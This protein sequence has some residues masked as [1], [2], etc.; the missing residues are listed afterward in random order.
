MAEVVI[1]DEQPIR[2]D[3]FLATKY[4]Y[5]RNFFHHIFQRWGILVNQKAVKKSYLLKIGDQITIDDLKRFF[6]PA[7]MADAP[8][9]ELKIIDEKTDYLVLYK[10]KG[11]LSHPSSIWSFHQP[12]VTGFLYHHYK[13]LPSLGS[14][15]RAGLIHRLDKDTDGLMLIIKSERWLA[16]FKE[17]FQQKS[18]A[19]TLE[20]KEL[21]PLKKFYKAKVQISPAGKQFLDSLKNFLPG[22]IQ[23]TVH[24]KVPH[25][26][27]KLGI[28][29]ILSIEE[30]SDNQATLEIEIL[31]WRTHQI[32]YHLANHGLPIIGDALYGSA[33][34][35]LLQ[36]TA[37]GLEFLDPDGEYRSFRWNHP[38]PP[39]S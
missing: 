25:P 24:A 37:F 38:L 29:K 32:R 1:F 13:N 12:S 23:E 6:D 18:L 19:E 16:H 34:D 3:S 14:F 7:M 21:V 26:Q 28:T 5:S 11:V 31:T 35:E 9:I 4:N 39:L 2:I 30:L 10:P 17:L 15:I 20:N 27:P 33:A 36:L 22:V 8:A